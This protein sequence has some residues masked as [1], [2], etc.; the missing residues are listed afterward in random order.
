[1][2][3]L[4][5]EEFHQRVSEVAKARKI[6]IPNITKNISEAFILYQEVLIAEEK[7]IAENITTEAGTRMPMLL[8]G[9]IRP[10]CPE[11]NEEMGLKLKA[12]DAKGKEWE[13]SWNCPKCLLEYYSEKTFDDWLKEL[14]RV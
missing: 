13:S 4:T 8:D 3:K 2:N 11:C 7:R 12:K 14:K 6:F 9:Y 1:M 5:S 10:K